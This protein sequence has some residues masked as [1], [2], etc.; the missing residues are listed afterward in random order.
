[1]PFSLSSSSYARPAPPPP[2]PIPRLQCPSLSPR[3]PSASPFNV[4]LRGSTSRIL[5]H[6]TCHRNTGRNT[7][8]LR[9]R[10]TAA[11]R[12]ATRLV[13]R[14]EEEEQR[15][16]SSTS[17]RAKVRRGRA[18]CHTARWG[19]GGLPV[20]PHLHSCRHLPGQAADRRRPRATSAPVRHDVCHGRAAVRPF[21]A[22]FLPAVVLQVPH[23]VSFPVTLH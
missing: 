9:R 16:P 6:S 7:A 14:A 3:P 15:G 2:H 4:S 22:S 20:C 10:E 1:M 5:T 21:G 11:V 19:A 23:S 8:I 17:P 13:P 18:A 12:P